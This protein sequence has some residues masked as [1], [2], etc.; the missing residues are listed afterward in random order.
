MLRQLWAVIIKELHLLRRD[1]GGLAVLFIMPVALVLVVC[2]VQDNILKTSGA[3]AVE[4][5]V[6]DHDQT[7]FGPWLICRLQEQD[8]LKV[9]VAADELSFAEAQRR[10]ERGEYQL[11]VYLAPELSDALQQALD[12]QVRRELFASAV[13]SKSETMPELLYSFDPAVQGGLRSGLT[14]LIFQLVQRRIAELRLEA[15]QRYLPKRIEH[16]VSTELGPM[17][18][19]ALAQHPLKLHLNVDADELM[20]VAP[21]KSEGGFTM[22]TSI[23]HNVPAWSIFGLFFMILPLATVMLQERAQGVFVRLQLIPGCG[24]SLLVGRVVAY[25]IISLAQFSLMLA[26]GRTLLPLLGTDPLDLQGQVPSMMVVSLC[27]ALAACGF[28][29]LLGAYARSSQQAVLT[30]A[31]A[32]VIF[33]ALGGIMIPVYLMPDVMQKVSV[34]S[35]LGWG[36]EAMQILVLRGGCLAETRP[37]LVRLVICFVVCCFFAWRGLRRRC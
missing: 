4:V 19:Q 10:V 17:F 32:I 16:Y 7:T 14:G 34:V 13:S 36:M 8:D 37:Y 24:V 25:L 2:L 22:P 26:V 11:G 31:V 21:L 15:F 3:G 18:S 6:V 1:R 33:A 5:L 27:V 29:L 30:A 35:P 20:P 9:S 12:A 28:G 23:Q